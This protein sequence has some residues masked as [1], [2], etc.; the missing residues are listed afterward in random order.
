MVKRIFVASWVILLLIVFVLPAAA[1]QEQEVVGVNL[2][3]WVGWLLAI[4]AL[5]LPL[6]VVFALRRRGSL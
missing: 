5:V 2:P 6:V 1:A 3:G 4:L